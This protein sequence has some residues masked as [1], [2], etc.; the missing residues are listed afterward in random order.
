MTVSSALMLNLP[1]SKLEQGVLR[2]LQLREGVC[3]PSNLSCEQLQVLSDDLDV[4]GIAAILTT[5]YRLSREVVVQ[6][7]GVNHCQASSKLFCRSTAHHCHDAFLSEVPSPF[8]QHYLL[9]LELP[10]QYDHPHQITQA[11]AQALCLSSQG[12]IDDSLKPA[13]SPPQK[14]G[15]DFFSF[16]QAFFVA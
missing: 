11:F 16:F 7:F 2:T 3:H 6:A 9:F 8:T 4:N 13:T 12:R 5:T 14:I 15:G 1:V 10:E